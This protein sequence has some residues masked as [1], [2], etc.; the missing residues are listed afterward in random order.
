[1]ELLRDAFELLRP[2]LRAV[3]ALVLVAA[4]LWISHRVIEGGPRKF[5]GRRFRR[6]LIMV[7]LTAIGVLV[8][9]MSLPIETTSRGQLL[10]FFGILL[11]AAIALASTTLLG[12][13]LAGVM[14][15]AVRS[16]RTGDFIRVGEFFG[17][18]SERGLVHTEIQLEDRNLT[19]LPNLYLV[20]HP[21]TVLRSS[22]TMV[23]AGVSLGYDVPRRRIESLLL[24][25][26]RECGL[27][28]PFVQICELGD[29]SVS[30]RV[31]GLL[32]EVKQILTMRSRLKACVLDALHRGGVEIVSPNFMNQRVFGEDRT[33]IPED[34]PERDAV[35][36]TP[37]SPEAAVFDKAEAAESLEG[38]KARHDELAQEIEALEGLVKKTS[39]GPEREPLEREL[40]RLGARRDSLE[41]VIALRE[42]RSEDD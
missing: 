7:G 40:A 41:R 9:L 1:M 39:K 27:E 42:T 15:R 24:E 19:T 26:A 17:R 36:G 34:A 5:W 38:L 31:A 37:S 8:V 35:R 18:V 11:S 14:L 2:A 28:D 33:F 3:V 25:A 6:Q 21:V 20:T 4:G 13:A 22:G 12:N 23:T 29:F 30:Y 32:T 10:S 16:F